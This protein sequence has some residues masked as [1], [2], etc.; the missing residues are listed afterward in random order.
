M[1]LNETPKGERPHIA[2]F[3]RTNV[4]KSSLINAVT[5]QDLAIV[6]PLKGTTTDPVQKA[7][8]ILPL[9]PVL[10]IDTPGIDDESLLGQARIAK[11]KEVLGHT[12]LAVFV[13]EA[14][15]SLT[16]EEKALLEHF[17]KEG[18]LFLS[19]ATKADCVACEQSDEDLCVSAKT[20]YHIDT[21]RLKMAEL[22]TKEKESTTN[23]LVRDLVGPEEVCLLVVPIDSAAPKG[24]LILPQQQ[25]IRDLLEGHAIPMVVA[26]SELSHAL[27][28][29]TPRLV[30]CDSQVFAEVSA[31]TDEAIPLTS[32]SILMAR[33]K[34][35][36]H[37]AIRGVSAI[38][39]LRSNDRI[40][41]AEGCTHHRQCDDIGSVKIPNW[42]R[43]HTGKDLLFETS[44]GNSFPTD[45]S[46]YALVVLC[47]GCM[48][49][50][51]EMQTR[52]QRALDQN[53]PVTNYGILIAAMKGILQ[54]S[55]KM[56]PT[57]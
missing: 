25:V 28:L 20:G 31:I 55:T 45:L 57:L 54:R 46:S 32:F 48:L 30:I 40:L 38:K 5:N 34:G 11:T 33:Y 19:V 49:N 12:D 14:G 27:T 52:M 9:G 4:G 37:E 2:F 22:L 6:S 23:V 13:H 44:S 42:L 1:S 41:M 17:K 15:Q 24:R 18:I 43:A 51:K 47:G 36:L 50:A 21:L 56:L 7:M 8:E 35:Y 39:K 29:V 53:I 16:K 3:G 26:P 10:L